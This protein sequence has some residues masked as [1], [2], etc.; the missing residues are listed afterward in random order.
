MIVIGLQVHI[1]NGLET[2]V[3]FI[4]SCRE[5]APNIIS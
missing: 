2:Y 1:N 5:S 3:G 4:K